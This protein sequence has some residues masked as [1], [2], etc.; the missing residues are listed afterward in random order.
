MSEKS[1]DDIAWMR[2]YYSR[3]APVYERIYDVTEPD[4]RIELENIESLLKAEFSGLDV[5]E[6]ACGSGYWTRR[7][8]PLASS[9]TAVDS[10]KQMLEI[11]R[12]SLDAINGVGA[13]V[14]FELAD[15]YALESFGGVYSAG[16]AGFWLSHVPQERMSDFLRGFHAKL[17]PGAMVIMFDNNPV[18]GLGGPIVEKPDS[19]DSYKR[20]ELPDGSEYV[21]V[22]NYFD[23]KS[24]LDIFQPFASEIQVHQ[25]RWYWWVKYRCDS[26]ASV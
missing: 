24:L 22:K 10:S 8:A 14:R 18:E 17:A 25:D 9:V 12:A 15:S 23:E 4:R 13:N 21:I 6:I 19:P 20:R 16:L 26:G 1:E 5:L 2:E 7:I 3:R 11:A